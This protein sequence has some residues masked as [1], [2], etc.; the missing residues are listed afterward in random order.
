MT[1]DPGVITDKRKDPRYRGLVEI[2]VCDFMT[3][4][5]NTEPQTLSCGG[6]QGHRGVE[7]LADQPLDILASSYRRINGFF[8]EQKG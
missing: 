4:L 1:Q 5:S 2:R 7:Y 3:G 6:F 8:E